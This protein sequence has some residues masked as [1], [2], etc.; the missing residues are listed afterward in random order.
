MGSVPMLRFFFA[1]SLARGGHEHIT[2][3]TPF[4]ASGQSQ[5]QV[6]KRGHVVKSVFYGL[7]N[8]YAFML[9]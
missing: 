9:M 7:Q 3:T 2:E 1:F 5:G 4:L 8:F 6:S